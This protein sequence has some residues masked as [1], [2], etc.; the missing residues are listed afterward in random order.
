MYE[1]DIMVIIADNQ[2]NKRFCSKIHLFIKYNFKHLVVSQL[3]KRTR[4]LGYVF[5]I[6]LASSLRCSVNL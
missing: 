5:L 1:V 2:C 3:N 4:F 6:L